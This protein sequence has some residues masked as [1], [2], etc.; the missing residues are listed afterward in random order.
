MLRLTDR[1][2]FWST[3]PIR[4]RC[5]PVVCRHQVSRSHA[6]VDA[7]LP[8][9]YTQPHSLQPT[10]TCCRY[11]HSRRSRTTHSDLMNSR[12]SSWERS[13]STI[14]PPSPAENTCLQNHKHKCDDLLSTRP[15]LTV[16]AW[17]TMCLFETDALNRQFLSTTLCSANQ[18][19]QNTLIHSEL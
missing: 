7:L 6:V 12:T 9:S 10:Q 17:S 3:D 16:T 5:P 8:L 14:Q 2:A 1:I 15:K 13:R 18:A 11:L 19:K 4:E